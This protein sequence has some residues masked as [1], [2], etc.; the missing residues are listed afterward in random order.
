[1]QGT[2]V[3]SLNREDPIGEGNGYPLQHSCLGNPIDRGSWQARVHGGQ[4]QNQ[5]QLSQ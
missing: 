2:R 5:T 3:Q 1:M 4:G